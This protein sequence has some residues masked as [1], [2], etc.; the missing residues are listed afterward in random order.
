MI[1]KR[2]I[3]SIPLVCVLF[4]TSVQATTAKRMDLAEL[5]QTAG[6]I[7]RG[8][9]IEADKGSKNAGSRKIPTVTYQ[10]RVT[11]T[12]KGSFPA[13]TGKELIV[14][15]QSVDIKAIELPKLSVGQEYLLMTT[16]PGASGLS[17]VVGLGQ[18][19]FRVYGEANSELAVNELNNAGLARGLSGPARY[20]DLAERIRTIV[21]KGEQK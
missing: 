7:F 12:L 3:A 1:L 15:M 19:A 11:E 6:L 14:S 21:R 17:T 8:T 10:I 13:A 4:A 9:V 16:T 5:A 2:C 20:D 18:G